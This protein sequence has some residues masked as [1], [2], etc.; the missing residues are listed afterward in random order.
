MVASFLNR[1]NSAKPAT[2]PETFLATLPRV[3][4]LGCM[5]DGDMPPF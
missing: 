2:L 1:C 5:M 4:G 3:A